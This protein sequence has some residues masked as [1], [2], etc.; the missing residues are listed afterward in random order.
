MDNINK[1]F[2]RIKDHFRL[3]GK[4][5][6]GQLGVDP[7]TISNIIKEKHTPNA[8]VL[9]SLLEFYPSISA[10]WLL[11]GVGS[12]FLEKTQLSVVREP[13]SS[14]AVSQ[15]NYAINRLIEKIG[16]LELL[17]DEL[18]KEIQALKENR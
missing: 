11:K 3:S 6:A 16:A 13:T 10:E 8:K 15:E 7:S 2:A 12:M 17:I 5:L 18:K 4:E 1:R 9:E 14:Y